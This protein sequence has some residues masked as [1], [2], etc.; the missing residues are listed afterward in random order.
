VTGQSVSRE[1]IHDPR[2]HSLRARQRTSR[3]DRQN[4]KLWKSLD[5]Y[6]IGGEARLE[7]AHRQMACTGPLQRRQV[8]GSL[9]TGPGQGIKLQDLARA[10]PAG[11]WPDDALLFHGVDQPGRA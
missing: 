6:V 4:L 10:A 2:R 7:L 5:F 8:V 9:L 1:F 11:I 3:C